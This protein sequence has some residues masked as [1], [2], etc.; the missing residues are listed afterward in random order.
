VVIAG[1][2]TRDYF[3]RLA[4]CHVHG[5]LADTPRVVRQPTR[6]I[7]IENPGLI[8]AFAQRDVVDTVLTGIS[9]SMQAQ[10]LGLL[11]RLESGFPHEA[12]ERIADLLP[13]DDT[14]RERVRAALVDVGTGI[15]RDVRERI[16]ENR[17]DFYDQVQTTV[18]FLPKNDL[19]AMAESMVGITSLKRK[20]T[21][22]EPQTVGGAIDVAVISKGEGLVWIKRK[23][24]FPQHL[25]P[26]WSTLHAVR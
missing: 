7:T 20:V 24:Y 3:P 16:E 18:A 13:P 12:F 5:V 26:N 14:A 21:H 23:H 17:A 2:G 15:A 22:S 6:A 8:A 9:P 11:G 4:A 10:I 25:N 1:F 19:A